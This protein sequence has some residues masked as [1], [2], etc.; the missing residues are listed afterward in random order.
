MSLWSLIASIP[1]RARAQRSAEEECRRRRPAESIFGSA[2][3]ADEGTRYVVRVFVGRR[4]KSPTFL[5]PPWR[6]CLVFAVPKG[7]EA[8]V[9]EDDPRYQP[10]LR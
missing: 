7:G 8:P 1:A 10:K 4:D 2:V 5:L 3:C 9:L 6:E